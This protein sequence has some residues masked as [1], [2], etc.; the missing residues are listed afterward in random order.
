MIDIVFTAEFTGQLSK[1][2]GLSLPGTKL[3]VEQGH[4]YRLTLDEQT[5]CGQLQDVCPSHNPFG[6]HQNESA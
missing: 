5:R 2:H 4:K 1:V 6:S 3:R